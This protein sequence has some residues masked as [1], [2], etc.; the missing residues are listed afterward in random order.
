[1]ADIPEAEALEQHADA[2]APLGHAVEPAEELEVLERR[3]LAVDERFVADVAD[4]LALRKLQLARGRR[5]EASEH[6]QQR[7]LARAVRP[8]DEE[9]A[10]GVERDVDAGED[11]LGAEA[12]REVASGEH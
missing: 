12:L 11:A 3:Q 8:R 7:R 9:E 10:A 1:M 2:L 6:A 4:H 5:G